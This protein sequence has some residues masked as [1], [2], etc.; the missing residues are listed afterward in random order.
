MGF[1]AI[2][3]KRYGV[4]GELRLTEN[5]TLRKVREESLDKEFAARMAK[6]GSIPK[7]ESASVEAGPKYERRG[8]L[9]HGGAE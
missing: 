5:L 4:D 3:I 6:V 9:F 8:F 2:E 7:G 1:K